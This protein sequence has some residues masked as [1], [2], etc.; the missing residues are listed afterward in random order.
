MMTFT[1]NISDI[2]KKTEVFESFKENVCFFDAQMSFFMRT[3]T[4]YQ[5]G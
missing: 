3:T 2:K 1:I 4:N 5:Y